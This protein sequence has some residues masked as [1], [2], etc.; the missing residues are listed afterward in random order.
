MQCDVAGCRVLYFSGH[1]FDDGSLGFESPQ[2]SVSQFRLPDL[3]VGKEDVHTNCCSSCCGFTVPIVILAACHS[4]SIGSALLSRG[5]RAVV[6]VDSAVRIRDNVAIGFSSALIRA[7]FNGQPIQTAFEAAIYTFDAA[8]EQAAR[9][10]ADAKLAARAAET[11]AKSPPPPPPPPPAPSAPKS[12]LQATAGL[13]GG[14]GTSVQTVDRCQ[15]KLAAAIADAEEVRKFRLLYHGSPSLSVFGSALPG[16]PVIALPFVPFAVAPLNPHAK[17]VALL[18]RRES[19]FQVIRALVSASTPQRMPCSPRHAARGPCPHRSNSNSLS[20]SSPFDTSSCSKCVPRDCPARPPSASASSSSSPASSASSAGLSTLRVLRVTAGEGMG[21]TA[22][23]NALVEHLSRRLH[24]PYRGAVRIMSARDLIV[25]VLAA[26]FHSSA[27]RQIEDGDIVGLT[28]LWVLRSLTGKGPSLG[29]TTAGSLS[30]ISSGVTSL[31]PA[32][33]PAALAALASAQGPPTPV[34]SPDATPVSTHTTIASSTSPVPSASSSVSSSSSSSSSRLSEALKAMWITSH[35]TLIPMVQSGQHSADALAFVTG[36]QRHVL[37]GGM[38][39]PSSG[40]L[41]AALDSFSRSPQ[42]PGELLQMR[43]RLA[44]TTNERVYPLT[45]ARSNDSISAPTPFSTSMSRITGQKD[46]GGAPSSTSSSRAASPVLSPAP[47][48][49]T[50]SSSR[51]PLGNEDQQQE[52]L[53]A[54]QAETLRSWES[55]DWWNHPWLLVLDEADYPCYA[56]A[57]AG[58]SSATKAIVASASIAYIQVLKALRSIPNVQMV[59]VQNP[60]QRQ[61]APHSRSRTGSSGSSN[62][63][64]TRRSMQGVGQG[65]TSGRVGDRTSNSFAFNGIGIGASAASAA[66]AGAGAGVGDNSCSSE[67]EDTD[68][69]VADEVEAV[70]PAEMLTP[71]ATRFLESLQ[72]AAPFDST[73]QLGCL[74]RRDSAELL[75][76]FMNRALRADD[77]DSGTITAS[78]GVGSDVLLRQSILD[79]V[80][81]IPARIKSVGLAARSKSLRAVYADILQKEQLALQQK[82]QQATNA[83]LALSTARRSASLAPGTMAP[84]TPMFSP[85]LHPTIAL[86]PS[87]LTDVLTPSAA[88]TAM[89]TGT[90]PQVPPTTAT[91]SNLPTSSSLYSSSTYPPLP[92]LAIPNASSD[93][94]ALFA[95]PSGPSAQASSGQAPVGDPS[96]LT[97]SQLSSPAGVGGGA[98]TASANTAAFPTSPLLGQLTTSGPLPGP[99]AIAMPSATPSA[100]AL[101]LVTAGSAPTYSSLHSFMSL[102]DLP[103]LPLALPTHSFSNSSSSSSSSGI[104]GARSNATSPASVL[105]ASDLS[106]VW[107]RTL[108]A[109]VQ[110]LDCDSALAAFKTWFCSM[111]GQLIAVKPLRRADPRSPIAP[112][113]PVLSRLPSTKDAEQFLRVYLD[114]ANLLPKPLS[115]TTE[116]DLARERQ[117]IAS[118]CASLRVTQQSLQNSQFWPWFQDVCVIVRKELRLWNTGIIYGCVTPADALVLLE[119]AVRKVENIEKKS[120]STSTTTSASTPNAE[121]ASPNGSLGG[122]STKPRIALLRFSESRHKSIALTMMGENGKVTNSAIML[123]DSDQRWSH[124]N[125]SDKRSSLLKTL[126]GIAYLVTANGLLTWNEAYD[127]TVLH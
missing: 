15:R 94:D 84:I 98:A 64:S 123:D 111:A 71:F 4:L 12:P 80:S 28:L 3:S 50:L 127:A 5:V 54:K 104:G 103:V 72:A 115:A 95:L 81:G 25:D 62:F 116:S 47:A 2:C 57:E 34:T 92:P 20:S 91:P 32:I 27:T 118:V 42:S 88:M 120:M 117:K 97:P 6:A 33:T 10:L 73:I 109:A 93:T 100:S 1:G 19:L 122:R 18:G 44:M 87:Y 29:Q 66:S 86:A 21:K 85:S 55:H 69:D 106:S 37:S 35:G 61:G 125:A 52:T 99:Q 126:Q 40:L 41:G 112:P 8:K 16:E 53:S 23:V 70:V 60:T 39:C 119:A 76:T 101:T 51:R 110:E 31:V 105:S 26:S 113:Q 17:P 102:P 89:S 108:S 22:F 11:A 24:V 65:L 58:R 82:Q 14:F 30:A 121:A 74:S 46:A 75:V 45:Q 96:A 78:Q 9:E 38:Q 83:E 68:G 79:Y 67:G 63:S 90:L 49:L 77:F 56:Y 13:T 7:I 43:V 59:L 114:K 36:G 107:N 48:Q 124:T